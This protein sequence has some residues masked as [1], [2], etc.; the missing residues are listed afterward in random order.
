MAIR[1]EW[2]ICCE[3][4]IQACYS[5]DTIPVGSLSVATGERRSVGR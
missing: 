4:C 3:E 2:E 1:D 5:S